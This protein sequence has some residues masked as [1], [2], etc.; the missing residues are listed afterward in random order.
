M[1]ANNSSNF[2]T[3]L[4]LALSG[5]EE[6]YT[7]GS[8]KKAIFLLSVPMILEMF[9]E[10]VFAI[11]DVYFVSKLGAN[12]VATIGITEAV[13]VL[14]YALAIGL[15]MGTTAIVSRRIGEKNPKGAKTAT[16]QAIFIGT[17]LSVFTMIPG[18]LFPKEILSL[19]GAET[20]LVEEG[21][22]YTQII[23]GS[24]LSIMLLF[25]IN[26]AFRGAGNASIAMKVLIFSNLLNIILDPIFI[27][28]FSIIPAYGIKGA[29][30]A[31][32]ISRSCGVVVQL[33]TLFF[34]PSRIKLAL[35]EIYIHLDTS[36]KLIKIAA[37]GV[38]QFIIGTSSWTV[39]MRLVANYGSDTLAGY[40]IAIRI[41]LFTLM[42]C[43]G[44]SNAAATLVGQN[45]G[46][47]QPE[48]AET[49]VWKTAKYCSIIMGVVSVLYLIF[50]EHLI[51]LFNTDTAIVKAGAL[52]LRVI[53]LAYILYAYG[54]VL[55]Q[56]FN[57]AGDSKTPTVI[58][59]ISFWL[60]QIPLAFLLSSYFNSGFIGV[61]AAIPIAESLLAILSIFIFK[62][63]KWKS[64]TV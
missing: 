5:K 27:F 42:P 2:L 44:M 48:R 47:Q 56:S 62:Q 57:G 23:L 32:A 7:T 35:H 26:A 6:D 53:A 12:A 33:F 14:I 11:F 15:S 4:K 46:A 18:I 50:A 10:S 51:T 1:A 34:R 22:R 45:L 16:V 49:S 39:L 20:D 52:S 30:I 31:T 17:L 59:F 43:F 9:M 37:P 61:L 36:W 63:G 40:T 24:N 19:M 29:A 21:Y 64:I 13:I 60:V 8:I 3:T 28:G 25:I 55:T 41:I 58:C 38:F 54:W